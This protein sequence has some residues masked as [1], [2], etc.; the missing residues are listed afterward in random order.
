MIDL[1]G[2]AFGFAAL[3]GVVS[4]FVLSPTASR[5]ESIRRGAWIIAFALVCSLLPRS[6]AVTA[7]SIVIGLMAGIAFYVADALELRASDDT[8]RQLE[9][10]AEEA[11][12]KWDASQNSAATA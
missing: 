12:A 10:I 6:M 2:I 7:M 1:N 11:K 9:Q 3:I 4:C 5:Y 8:Q